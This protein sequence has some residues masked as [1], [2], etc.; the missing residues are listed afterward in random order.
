MNN[1]IFLFEGISLNKGARNH[2][3]DNAKAKIFC[4]L[5][6]CFCVYSAYPVFGVKKLNKLFSTL[7]FV[8]PLVNSIRILRHTIVNIVT[9][10]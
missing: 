6:L 9:F 7:K 5:A 3:I 8:N 1:F 10:S 4:F 2:V